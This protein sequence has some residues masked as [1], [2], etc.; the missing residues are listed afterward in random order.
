[1]RGY[2]TCGKGYLDSFEQLEIVLL[3]RLHVVTGE[4]AE[5]LEELGHAVLN[6]GVCVE[7]DGSDDVQ[8]VLD[9]RQDLVFIGHH[10]PGLHPPWH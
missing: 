6:E 1:M 4:N 9:L 7:E 8:V 5:F 2:P 10:R 3:N